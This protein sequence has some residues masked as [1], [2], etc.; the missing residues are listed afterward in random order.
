MPS[1]PFTA[2]LASIFHSAYLQQDE[3]ISLLV[4]RWRRQPQGFRAGRTG[5]RMDLVITVMQRATILDVGSHTTHCGRRQRPD[6]E[7]S[8]FQCGQ[9]V[10][11]RFSQGLPEVSRNR[12]E[13]R[14]LRNFDSSLPS[15]EAIDI[16]RLDCPARVATTRLAAVFDIHTEDNPFRLGGPAAMDIVRR[17]KLADARPDDGIRWRRTRLRSANLVI[18]RIAELELVDERSH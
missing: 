15:L 14:L 6:W 1:G 5:R 4:V 18:I 10:A 2:R 11:V 8:A 13:V 3:R 9:E 17:S 12:A 16:S 7:G